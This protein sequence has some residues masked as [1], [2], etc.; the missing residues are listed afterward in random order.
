L[1]DFINKTRISNSLLLLKAKRDCNLEDI[2]KEVGFSNVRTFSR[3][4]KKYEGVAPGKFK[5][6]I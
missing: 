1:L 5:D 6:M 4:F 2:A 3:V